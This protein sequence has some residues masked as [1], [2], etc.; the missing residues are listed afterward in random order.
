MC[1]LPDASMAAFGMSAKLSDAMV[2]GVAAEAA[3]GPT[4]SAVTATRARLDPA[5]RHTRRPCR[6]L[7]DASS[8]ACGEHKPA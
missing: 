5:A 2:N 6:R 1:A 7:V 3:G 4:R 8:M